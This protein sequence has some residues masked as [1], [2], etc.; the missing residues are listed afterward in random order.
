M[1]RH[2]LPA[3]AATTRV[4][5]IDAA[6]P[7]VLVVEDGD[8]VEFET[9]SHWAGAVEPTMS[10]DDVVALRDGYPLGPHTITG[11]VEVRGAAPGDVLR[12]EVL[13]L[14]PGEWGFNL[15]LPHPLG[16]GVLAGRFPAG[17]LHHF[18]LDRAAMATELGGVRLALRP[19]PGIM[20]VAPPGDGPHSS[21]PPGPF[22]GN[23]DLRDLVVGTSLFLP[24]FRPGAGF[25]VGDAH[26]L[27]GDGE[28]NQTAIETSMERARVRLSTHR[29]DALPALPW[30]ETPSHLVALG[31]DEDLDL[32]VEAAVEALVTHLVS[33]FGRRGEEAYALCSLC[34]DVGATQVVNRVKGAHARLPWAA[35]GRSGPS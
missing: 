31:L 16:R 33:R 2:H 5:V 29:Y 26:A 22:G 11:P 13:E 4:G 1:A 15:A 18:R 7:A 34:A 9:L 28:V 23:L 8:E 21:V 6:H 3:N 10:L 20:G 14:V 25:Y 30:A 19:F 35:L 24:V 32:A 12:A 27:Q 17:A